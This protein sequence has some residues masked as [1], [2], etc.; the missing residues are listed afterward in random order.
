MRSGSITLPSALPKGKA[1]ERP[2]GVRLACLRQAQNLPRV[3]AGII[4]HAPVAD[5]GLRGHLSAV[6][7]TG[8]RAHSPRTHPPSLKLRRAGHTSQ[9][10]GVALAKTNFR[11]RLTLSRRSASARRRD[12]A[13]LSRRSPLTK[14]DALLLAF[15]SAKTWRGDFH[16][17]SPVPCPAHTHS[18]AARSFL[19]VRL[20]APCST[21]FSMSGRLRARVP[22]SSTATFVL[23]STVARTRGV[24]SRSG[25]LLLAWE[26]GRPL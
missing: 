22:S 4:K 18:S 19:R 26:R 25:V 1:H 16:P 5:G 13:L 7:G 10:P 17:T 15:G 9:R 8:R 6:S 14:E 2:P 20:Q 24:A 21:R 23:L 3:N 12:D 11:P